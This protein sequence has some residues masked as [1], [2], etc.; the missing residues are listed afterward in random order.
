MRASNVVDA[1]RCPVRVAEVK[2]GEVAM[3]VLLGAMLIHALHAA[4]EDGEITLDRVR[5]HG[6]ISER[7]ILADLVVDDAMLRELSGQCFLHGDVLEIHA[8][9]DEA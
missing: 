7:D 4:L 8:V 3:Q 6:G 9:D 5:M 2:L 1:E